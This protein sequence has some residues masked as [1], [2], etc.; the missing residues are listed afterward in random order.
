MNRE[1]LQCCGIQQYTQRSYRKQARYN[2]T[3]KREN[4]YTDVAIPAGKN[5][6]QKETEKRI[7]YKRFVYR[8]TTNVEPE[9]NKIIL[10]KIGTT[11]IVTKV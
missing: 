8:D 2:S 5:V 3:Q 1:M 7:K 4:M 10:V 6:L 9:K 11:E